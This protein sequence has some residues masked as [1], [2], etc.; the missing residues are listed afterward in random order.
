[1]GKNKKITVHTM[2]RQRIKETVY[3][4]DTND[5]YVYENGQVRECAWRK[6]SPLWNEPT[7]LGVHKTLNREAQGVLQAW[8]MPWNME[9]QEEKCRTAASAELNVS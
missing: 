8:R 9:S 3:K 7:G 4:N 1:M 5:E 2:V 6:W